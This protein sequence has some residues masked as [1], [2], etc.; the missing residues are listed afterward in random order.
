MRAG[1]VINNPLNQLSWSKAK[2]GANVARRKRMICLKTGREKLAQT[3]TRKKNLKRK[4]THRNTLCSSY[5]TYAIEITYEY[6]YIQVICLKNLFYT[7][8]KKITNLPSSLRFDASWP[9]RVCL[10]GAPVLQTLVWGRPTWELCSAW[11]LEHRRP[12][13]YCECKPFIFVTPEFGI[14]AKVRDYGMVVVSREGSNPEKFIYNS[15]LLTKYR[16]F[17]W[18]DWSWWSWQPIIIFTMLVL[19]Q[20]WW[21]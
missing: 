21:P 17:Q 9:L 10:K 3:P 6:I 18:F 14:V 15:D 12:H 5:Y 13:N 20:W 7:Y 19:A 1:N 2:A 11:S 8:D 16:F 4:E